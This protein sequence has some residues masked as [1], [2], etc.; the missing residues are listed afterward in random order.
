MNKLKIATRLMLLIGVLAAL[1][2][3]V[4]LTGLSGINQSNAALKTVYE[5][6]TV[7]MG[8]LADVQHQVLLNRVV[9]AA[10]ARRTRRAIHP[11]D[12]AVNSYTEDRR[13]GHSRPSGLV[14]A[15]TCSG[16]GLAL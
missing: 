2:M 3:A 16:C 10:S 5:D 12:R 1:L 15:L 11:L 7:P 6:R 9:D 8:Q 4:G 14:P 13:A